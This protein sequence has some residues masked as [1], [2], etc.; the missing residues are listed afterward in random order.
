MPAYTLLTNEDQYWGFYPSPLVHTDG[1]IFAT[2]YACH[3]FCP[4]RDDGVDGAWIVGINPS[5]GTEK[6]RAPLANSVGFGTVSDATFCQQI[7]GPEPLHYHSFPFAMTIAG[8]GYAY[9][10]YQTIDSA[11]TLKRAAALP[12]PDAT[13]DAFDRLRYDMGDQDRPADF[14]A[15]LADLEALYASTGQTQPDPPE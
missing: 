8:D 4:D 12:F 15:A 13:Y 11:G 6:F 5:T 9:L 2:E 1:T 7:P 10:S 14:D 3:D